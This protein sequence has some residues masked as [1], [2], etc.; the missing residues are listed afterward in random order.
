MKLVLT[1]K[2]LISL[3]MAG[4]LSNFKLEDLFSHYSKNT[5]DNYNGK[6]RYLDW[7]TFRVR[8]NQKV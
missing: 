3:N 5:P 8:D 4:F 6:E 2:K 7:H 1:F